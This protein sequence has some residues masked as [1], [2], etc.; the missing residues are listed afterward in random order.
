MDGISTVFQIGAAL[1]GGWVTAFSKAGKDAGGLS[2]AFDKI[3]AKKF[4]FNGVDKAEGDLKKAQAAL[5]KFQKKLGNKK[6]T[7]DQERELNR[8]KKNV[9]DTGKKFDKANQKVSDWKKTLH[10]NFVDVDAAMRLVKRNDALDELGKKLSKLREASGAALG[11]LKSFGIGIL[12]QAS[13]IIASTV[14]VS[15]WGTSMTQAAQRLNMFDAAGTANVEQ[16]QRMQWAATRANI[17]NEE[18]VATLDNMNRVIGQAAIQGGETAKAFERLGL[19]SKALSQLG[20]DKQFELIVKKLEGVKNASERARIAQQIWGS[21]AIGMQNLISRGWKNISADMNDA[22]NYIVLGNKKIA[23]SCGEWDSQMKI[24]KMTWNN[25]FRY[26]ILAIMPT[27]TEA[28]KNLSAVISENKGKIIEFAEKISSF[29]VPIVSWFS[30]NLDTL[31]NIA[32]VCIAAFGAWKIGAFAVNVWNTGTAILSI[33]KSIWALTKTLNFAAVAQKAVS[34]ATLVWSGITK[35]MTAAQ[36]ALNVALNANPIGL[37]VLAVAALAAAAYAVIA[38][39]DSIAEFF[40]GVW[41]GIVSGCKKAWEW[42]SGIFARAKDAV[43]AVAGAIKDAFANAWNWIK[44][45]LWGWIENSRI[46]KFFKWAQSKFSGGNDDEPEESAAA[47]APPIS[48]AELE[49]MS[50]DAVSRNSSVRTDARTF[51]TNANIS[52]IQQPGEDSDALAQ[53]ISARLADSYGNAAVAA[54]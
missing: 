49:T 31:S 37:V 13:A 1:T 28:M 4:S 14:A 51:N 30:R 15:D 44:T 3:G 48:A 6:P 38:N 46:Y 10:K 24:L 32:Y 40:S 8:L 29:V 33:T 42:M 39:W 27:V 22:T 53:R 47:S 35:A 19:S 34:A 9:E 41:D 17:G 26:A 36:W 23:D 52:I 12:G 18:F 21:G 54:I 11:G 20:A 16:L 45:T 43:Y 7:A 2:R 50:R 5:E 25:V